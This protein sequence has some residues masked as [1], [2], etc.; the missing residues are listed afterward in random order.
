MSDIES[1]KARLDIVDIIS[2]Y[3]EL[4][5]AGS[6]YKGLSPFKGEKTPSLMV[7][8][9]LQIFKDFSSGIGGDVITFIQEYEKLT[10][11]EA[12]EKC[13]ELAGITLTEFNSNKDT[14]GE[15]L[16]KRI[17]EANTLA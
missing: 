10:F 5:P 12:L 1:I 11:K 17:I 15:K 13:A 16:K 7:S 3:V 14:E 8:P 4:K 2:K 6:N 9:K